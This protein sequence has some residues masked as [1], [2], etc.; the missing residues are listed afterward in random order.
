[1]RITFILPGF[2]DAPMG[3][4]KVVVEYANRLAGRG[5]RVTLIYPWNIGRNLGKIILKKLTGAP[6]DLYYRP[7]PEVNTVVVRQIAP[8]YIPVS[9][10]I[11]AV[12]WQTAQAV[13]ELPAEHGQKFYF[14]QSFET[15][16]RKKRRVLESYHLP[17]RKIAVSKWIMT[18]LEHLGETAFG[19]LGNAINPQEFFLENQ[20]KSREDDVVF[21]YHHRRI[22]GARTGLA[23]LRR[24]KK[25]FPELKAVIVSPRQPLHRI[26]R[27]CK[28]IIRPDIAT[29]RRLYNSTKVLLFTSRWEGWGLPPMEALACGCGVV[30]T[31]NRGVMEYLVHRENALICR[32]DDV[33]ELTLQTKSLLELQEL[34]EQLCKNGLVTIKRFDGE[35]CAARF[36]SYL[37]N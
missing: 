3:G 2:I 7:S 11:I 25:Q 10:A 13:A 15:Y 23:V 14:L 37:R 19:P 5:H 4:V 32:I 30:A 9:D 18:E 27:W 26:P 34:R 31:D 16:F 17:L 20:G 35:A 6:S 21:L 36:E 8:K 22:K 29:L 1:M 12:G 24:L 28:V 33:A